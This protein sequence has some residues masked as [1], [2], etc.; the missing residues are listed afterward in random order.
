[1]AVRFVSLSLGSGRADA[2]PR[3]R[4]RRRVL[5]PATPLFGRTS[6]LLPLTPTRRRALCPTLH[7]QTTTTAAQPRPVSVVLVRVLVLVLVYAFV[8]GFS[9]L[10]LCRRRTLRRRSGRCRC[11]L[12]VAPTLV[13]VGFSR[14]SPFTCARPPI[15]LFPYDPPYPVRCPS[16]VCITRSPTPC[17]PFPRTRATDDEL[18]VVVAPRMGSVRCSAAVFDVASALSFST[19]FFL[20]VFVSS[21]SRSS[22]FWRMNRVSGEK[23]AYHVAR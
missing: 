8:S 22:L 20:V 1:M 13:V 10:P 4:W 3:R 21:S 9:A 12:R 16:L 2:R 19:I 11:R 15:S 23:D 18:G 6:R 5:L 14:G 17:Q 7:C